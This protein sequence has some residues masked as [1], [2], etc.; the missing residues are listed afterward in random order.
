MVGWWTGQATTR[1]ERISSWRVRKPIGRP[2]KS[3][4]C[5]SDT[6]PGELLSGKEPSASVA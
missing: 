5:S 2:R 4:G 3:A 1:A 6:T